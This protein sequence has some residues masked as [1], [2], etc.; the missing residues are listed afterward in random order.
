MVSL[1]TVQLCH[2][3]AEAAMATSK[4]WVQRCSNKSL[5]TGRILPTGYGCWLRRARRLPGSLGLTVSD[6]CFFPF[7]LC[8]LGEQMHCRITFSMCWGRKLVSHK[9]QQTA[10]PSNHVEKVLPN[11]FVTFWVHFPIRDGDYKWPLQVWSWKSLTNKF[12]IRQNVTKVELF[13]SIILGV[14]IVPCVCIFMD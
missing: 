14:V 11:L 3:S 8:S 1:G 2:C 4:Q 7:I 10:P 12:L 6:T 13:R 9:E 5:L